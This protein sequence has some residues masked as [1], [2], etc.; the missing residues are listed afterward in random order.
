MSFRS[1]INLAPPCV[2]RCRPRTRAEQSR[3]L[4]CPVPT[5]ILASQIPWRSVDAAELILATRSM[6][7]GT[8]G[9]ASII[10][11]RAETRQPHSAFVDPGHDDTRPAPRGEKERFDSF[12]IDGKPSTRCRGCPFVT[13]MRSRLDAQARYCPLEPELGAERAGSD[14]D[15]LAK[16]WLRRPSYRERASR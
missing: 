10:S 5:L 15:T 9:G 16:C 4:M 1:E 8:A 11:L 6:R 13:S 2:A 7:S 12:A 14:S 3:E